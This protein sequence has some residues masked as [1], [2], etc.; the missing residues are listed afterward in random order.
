MSRKEMNAELAADWLR[1]LDECAVYTEAIESSKKRT[2]IRK[3]TLI[4]NDEF[5]YIDKAL[6][7]RKP[8]KSS[9][10]VTDATTYDAA[11]KYGNDAY[12]ACLLN[13]ASYYK[14]GG[15]YVKGSYAQEESLC[16]VSGLYP[17]LKSQPVYNERANDK[18]VPYTY[19]SEIIYSPN[20]PFTMTQGSI[21]FPYL[22]DVI[23]CAAPNCNK[24]PMTKSDSVERAIRE[25]LTGC[26]LLPW[27]NGCDTII[28]GAW[29]CGVFKNDPVIVA[30]VFNELTDQ[31]GDL[32]SNIIYAVPNGDLR[33]IF[34]SKLCK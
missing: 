19:R 22:F 25:R 9:I 12:K 8:N 10:I 11:M 21:S 18:N 16:A 14:P 2:F 29:G 33:K 5:A 15:G 24:V 17:I 13:F 31:Y 4:T 30:G 6:K 20:V 34:I 32:Y 3:G 28:L 26:F 1:R 23:S 7:E 27:L